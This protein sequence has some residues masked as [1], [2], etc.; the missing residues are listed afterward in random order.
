MPGTRYRAPVVPPTGRGP[1]VS[2]RR[3]RG[4]PGRQRGYRPS[5]I[6]VRRSTERRTDELAALLEANLPDLSDA[7][8]EGAIVVLD[9]DRIRIRRL[10][11]P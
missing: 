11:L 10:P 1:A 3:L 6:I 5:V 9:A 7:L 8:E 2:G 4:R